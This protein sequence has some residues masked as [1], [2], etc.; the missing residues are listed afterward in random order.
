MLLHLLQS[1][2]R[3]RGA[4]LPGV[5]VGLV[6]HDQRLFD[7]VLHGRHGGADGLAAEAVGN[8][9][10]MGQAVLDAR[11]QHRGGPVVAVGGPVLIEEVREL[12][13]HLPVKK[14]GI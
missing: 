6:Y 1:L 9:A 12:L 4:L 7:V 13:A 8:Q 3:V 5:H 14:T 2:V 11:L 10:E